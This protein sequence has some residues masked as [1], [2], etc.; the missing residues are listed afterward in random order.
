MAEKS[1]RIHIRHGEFELDIE[2]DQAFVESYLEAFLS[3]GDVEAPPAAMTAPSKGRRKGSRRRP[4]SKGNGQRKGKYQIPD[5]DK[6]LL[7]QF[8]GKKKPNSNKSRYLAY[9]QFW[10][11]HGL[12]E[13]ADVHIHACF[14]AQGLPVPPTGRQH[15]RSLQEEGLVV[16][17]SRRGLWALTEAG[18]RAAVP[19]G[20]ILSGRRPKRPVAKKAKAKTVKPSTGMAGRAKAAKPRKRAKA[21]ARRKAPKPSPEASAPPK[22]E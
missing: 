16:P 21:P 1:Y 10:K 22:T 7:S 20:R 15:F 14:L 3:E 5:I 18:E 12:K 6:K 8:M 17:G 13:V 11:G 4:P 9:L 2:G 19:T